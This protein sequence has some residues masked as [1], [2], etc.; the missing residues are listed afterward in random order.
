MRYKMKTRRTGMSVLA[1]PAFFAQLVRRRANDQVLVARRPV[2]TETQLNR[3]DELP[4]ASACDNG[5][6][7]LRAPPPRAVRVKMLNE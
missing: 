2:A 6:H 4:R 1:A 3:H 7:G 5:S